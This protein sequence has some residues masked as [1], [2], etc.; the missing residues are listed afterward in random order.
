[1]LMTGTD[2]QLLANVYQGKD[3]NVVTA[4]GAFQTFT[5]GR[6]HYVRIAMAPAEDQAAHAE[7]YRITEGEFRLYFNQ[8]GQAVRV[9]T[10]AKVYSDV[11]FTWPWSRYNNKRMNLPTKNV[12]STCRF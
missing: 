3:M 9:E 7:K 8:A 10:R 1:M 2:A 6:E 5:E 12:K 11:Y 4:M